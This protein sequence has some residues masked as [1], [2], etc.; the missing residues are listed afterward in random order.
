[1]SVQVVSNGELFETMMNKSP[2]EAEKVAKFYDYIEV[3]PKPVYSPL[4]DGGM[5]HGEW[6]LEDIIRR[7]V[8]LGKKLNKPVVATGNVH[9]LDE[10]DAIFRQILVGSQGGANPLNRHPLPK[11]HFRTTNEMLKEFDFLGPD[12][13]KE[14]VVTNTQ[15][16]ADMIGEVV[17]IKDDLYTPKIEG[18]NEEVTNMTYEMAHQIYGE[19]L[20]EIVETRI[21][22]EL[23]SILGHGFGVVY[24][25]SAKL[26]K[27]SLS[28]G[29]LVGSRGSVGSSFVATMMEITE[30]NPLAP[31]YIC[32]NCNILNS[33]QMV[34]LDQGLTYQIKN[35]LNVEQI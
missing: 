34:Q 22:K 30:V 3:M 11:V 13:A 35:V 25:I 7:I 31:H 23:D 16:I 4:V 9:Y 19:N 12:L 26:V 18:S 33:L 24:L 28:D 14:V 8:K 20:P 15:N 17:P 27:K 6:T 32:P 21:D 1:M 2:E 10:N 5:I 29:Y